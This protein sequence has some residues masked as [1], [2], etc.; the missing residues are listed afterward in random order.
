MRR[1]CRWLWERFGVGLGVIPSSGEGV[2]LAR[3][4]LGGGV[5]ANV[6]SGRRG[7]VGAAIVVRAGNMSIWQERFVRVGPTASDQVIPND[8]F[9]FRVTHPFQANVHISQLGGEFGADWLG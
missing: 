1:V 2:R 8:F 3:I 6:V 9:Q 7:I 4:V 5:E